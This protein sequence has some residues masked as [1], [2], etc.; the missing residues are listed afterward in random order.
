PATELQIVDFRFSIATE[1]TS[2]P[3]NHIV[4]AS[5]FSALA[6][7]SILS[8]RPRNYSLADRVR[9][10]AATTGVRICDLTIVIGVDSNG[11]GETPRIM[12]LVIASYFSFRTRF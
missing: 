12:K 6:K 8:H 2:L 4:R 7:S 9:T 10:S 3:R 1:T 11:V 5:V